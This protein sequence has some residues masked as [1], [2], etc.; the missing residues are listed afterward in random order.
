MYQ[1]KLSYLI[2]LCG[3]LLILASCRQ[4]RSLSSEK[5]RAVTARKLYSSVAGNYLNYHTVSV[6]FSSGFS[7]GDN[8]LSFSGTMRIKKDSLI[9]VSIAPALGIEVARLQFTPDSI[10]FINYLSK[11]YFIKSFESFGNKFQVDISYNDLQSILMNEIFLYSESSDELNEKLNQDTLDVDYFRKTFISTAD[12]NRYVLK[13]HRNFKIRKHLKKN[14]HNDLIVETI[15]VA[16][17]IFKITDVEVIDF[18]EKRNLI[19]EYSKFTDIINKVFPTFISVEITTPEK[20]IK[21][22][23]TYNKITVNPDVSFPFKI[24]EKYKRIN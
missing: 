22:E 19:I 9:W 10:M 18:N 1:P 8:N 12:S 3:I 7:S 11:E 14:K 15:K 24:T 16:P 20:K 5:V 21:S 2:S 6:K 17:E 4:T 23:I 13:T